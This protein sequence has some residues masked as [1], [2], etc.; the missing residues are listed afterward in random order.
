MARI[1]SRSKGAGGEREFCRWLYDNMNVP[2]PK[3]N[4][5]QVREGGA[6]IIDIEPFFFE[7]KRCEVLSLDAWWLQV[8]V[9]CRESGAIQEPMPVVCFR[10]NRKPW[11]FLISAKHI[12]CNKGYIRINERIFLEFSA[13]IRNNFL[14]YE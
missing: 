5:D 10:K 12:N 14:E 8:V 2:L 13:K 6:D 4:L 1:N 9:A 3:R 11:E 7:I